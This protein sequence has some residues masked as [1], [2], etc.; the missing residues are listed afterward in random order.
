M[1]W[2]AKEFRERHAKGLSP[3]QAAHAAKMANAML[4]HGTDEGTA[5]ATAIKNSKKTPGQ[6]LHGK[7]D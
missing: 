5:I 1:P 4:K 3:A 7:G 6:L 2:T